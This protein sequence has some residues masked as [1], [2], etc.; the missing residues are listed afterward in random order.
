MTHP[1][2]IDTSVIF[3]LSGIEGKKSS[4]KNLS[5]YLLNQKI[6]IE[7]NKKSQPEGHCP[8]EDASAA[9]KLVKR[10]LETGKLQ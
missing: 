4:L 6:Q 7:S 9:L 8:I 2:V 1:Y 3:N 10:K 5:Y